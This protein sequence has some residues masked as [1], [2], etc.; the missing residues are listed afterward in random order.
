MLR[1]GFM[2]GQ[3]K[4]Q[5]KCGGKPG[6][7]EHTIPLYSTVAVAIIFQFAHACITFI[8]EKN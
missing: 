8:A 2:D 3:E 4:E 5:W 7:C 1:C 6:M